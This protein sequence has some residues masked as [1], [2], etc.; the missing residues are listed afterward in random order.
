[1]A[2]DL[3]PLSTLIRSEGSP[4]FLGL[5]GFCGSSPLLLS[6]LG[7]LSGAALLSIPG[8]LSGATL[9]NLALTPQSDR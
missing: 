3:Y 9:P 1:M 4:G 2:G 8:W 5:F 7:W 6:I